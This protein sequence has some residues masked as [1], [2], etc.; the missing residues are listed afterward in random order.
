MKGQ[1]I[2][3]AILALVA[4]P[5]DG[6]P[7]GDDVQ[8][9]GDQLIRGDSTVRVLREDRF[10]RAAVVKDVLFVPAQFALLEGFIQRGEAHLVVGEPKLVEHPVGEDEALFDL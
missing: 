8:V 4:Q 10:K 3:L 7:V 6:L 5:G 1:R 9:V 2:D